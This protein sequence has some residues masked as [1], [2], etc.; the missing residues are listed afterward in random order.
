LTSYTIHP[1][2]LYL[3]ETVSRDELTN[4]NAEVTGCTRFLT[5]LSRVDG[6]IWVD[7]SLRLKGF[8][9]EIA[10][11]SDPTSTFSAQNAQATKLKKLDLNHFGTRHRSMLRY[12]AA[13]PNSVG[14]VVSQDGDVRAVSQ[15]N[16]RVLLWDNIR[17]Q[18]LKNARILSAEQ[19]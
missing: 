16:N 4:T 1:L 6:L 13:N 2:D 12:C 14:F 10:S 15:F 11:Q 17:I 9:V 3:D 8:G 7:S 5:S 19:L 18:S